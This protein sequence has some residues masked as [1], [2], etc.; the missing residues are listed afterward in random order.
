MRR[1]FTIDSELFELEPLGPGPIKVEEASSHY[2]LGAVQNILIIRHV[3][4]DY[5]GKR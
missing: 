5:D 3:A 2:A 4:D 1:E